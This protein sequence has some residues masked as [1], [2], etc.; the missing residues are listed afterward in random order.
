LPPL[1][2]DAY[3]PFNAD[4]AEEGQLPAQ[5]AALEPPTHTIFLK[6]PWPPAA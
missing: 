6:V 1:S 4:G 3:D 2:G 5:Q